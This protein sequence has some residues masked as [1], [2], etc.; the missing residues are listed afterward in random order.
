MIKL[1]LIILL[2]EL[3]HIYRILSTWKNSNVNIRGFGL[4]LFV[5]QTDGHF[6]IL[7]NVQR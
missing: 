2:L 1:P 4:F 6:V 7:G 3:V 5:L